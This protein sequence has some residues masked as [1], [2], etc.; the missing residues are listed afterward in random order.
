[1]AAGRDDDDEELSAV[2][3]HEI[4]VL[5]RRHVRGG[6]NGKADLVRRARDL[7]GY[8]G[9]QSL[10][11]SGAP[12][13]RFDLRRGRDDERRSDEQLIDVQPIAQVGGHASG[14]CVRLPDI[15]LLL[16]PRHDVPKR[17]GGHPEAA[18]GQPQRRDGLALLDVRLDKDPENPSIPFRQFRMACH[19]YLAL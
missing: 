6:R 8:V 2:E 11:S 5:E 14:G 15:A 10:D 7:L 18:A 3:R 12:E 1:M 9:E 19:G 17:G 4:Q 16:E 13:P